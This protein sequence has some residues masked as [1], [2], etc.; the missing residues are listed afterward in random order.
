MKLVNKLKRNAQKHLEKLQNSNEFSEK[1][2]GIY[3]YLLLY[4]L[5]KITFFSIILKF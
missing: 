2:E 3:F 5:K 1:G 4:F